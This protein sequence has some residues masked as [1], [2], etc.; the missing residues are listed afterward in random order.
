METIANIDW[1]TPN[2]IAVAILRMIKYKTVWFFS[3]S[4]NFLN[5]N[6]LSFDLDGSTEN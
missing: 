1:K 4:W 2:G 5:A 3:I 6:M